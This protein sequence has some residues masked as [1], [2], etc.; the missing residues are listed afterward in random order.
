MKTIRLFI[1]AVMIIMTSVLASAQ[2]RQIS[3]N[4]VDVGGHPLG[5]ATVIITGT[6]TGVSTNVNGEY[7][8]TAPANASLTVSFIGYNEQTVEINGRS[9]IDFVLEEDTSFLDEVTVVAFG[10][11]RK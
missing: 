3:G 8:I 2:N 6:S 11:K 5:G 9:V 7:A 10:T 4:V 1:S